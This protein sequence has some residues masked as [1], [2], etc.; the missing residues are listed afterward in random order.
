MGWFIDERLSESIEVD[1]KGCCRDRGRAGPR[2]RA[3]VG[4]RAGTR[5]RARTASGSAGQGFECAELVEATVEPLGPGPV[6][7][8]A[9]GHG[10]R[11]VD[12]PAGESDQP[13]ANGAGDG[14]A[15]DGTGLAEGVGP[16]DQVGGQR[17]RTATMRCWR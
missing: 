1:V 14:E 13:R 2:V 7:R 16:A 8:A 17:P 15:V 6:E 10:A 9:Q 4:C 12:E 3:V 11:P 5:V